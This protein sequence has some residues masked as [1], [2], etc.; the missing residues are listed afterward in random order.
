M[1]RIRRFVGAFARAWR[2]HQR[3]AFRS[4]CSFQ[5]HDIR[6]LDFSQ[7]LPHLLR[8]LLLRVQFRVHLRQLTLQQCQR[9]LRL[10]VLLLQAREQVPCGLQLRFKTRLATRKRMHRGTAERARLSILQIMPVLI[11]TRHQLRLPHDLALHF[12]LFRE[13]LLV[14]AFLLRFCEA[15]GGFLRPNRRLCLRVG[16][17]LLQRF[18]LGMAFAALGQ[19]FMRHTPLTHRHAEFRQLLTQL[20][21]GGVLLQP[22]FQRL[23][24]LLMGDESFF[25]GFTLRGRFL[26]LLRPGLIGRATLHELLFQLLTLRR[27][28]RRLLPHRLSLRALGFGFFGDGSRC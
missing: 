14:V 20:G 3:L 22:R 17:P 19:L 16:E 6:H 10:L 28:P 15:F 24:G 27:K 1:L 18:G 25:G 5:R 21:I 2:H 7:R 23:R 9:P 13:L 26:L 8:S 12:D 4:L 11:K